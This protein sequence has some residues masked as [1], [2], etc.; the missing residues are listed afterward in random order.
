MEQMMGVTQALPDSAVPQPQGGSRFA[1]LRAAL[2]LLRVSWRL[3]TRLIIHNRRVRLFHEK[4]KVALPR[5]DFDSMSLEQLLAEY[6]SLQSTVI[7]AWDVPLIN[8]L[9]CMVFHGA[10]R[11]LCEHW[12]R[13]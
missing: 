9:Y 8:D 1:D 5:I 3:T 11:K 10:L 7:P 6:E 12:L 2:G 13:P 4:L